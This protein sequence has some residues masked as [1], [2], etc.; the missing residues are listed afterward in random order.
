MAPKHKPEE[1][2][3]R[4]DVAVRRELRAFVRMEPRRE[5]HEKNPKVALPVTSLE[6]LTGNPD[7]DHL[8]IRLSVD[9]KMLFIEDYEDGSYID[10]FELHKNTK[11]QMHARA[12]DR[13]RTGD[14]GELQTG[15]S[16]LT[17]LGRTNNPFA[18]SE[19][20]IK[21]G[22]VRAED[23]EPMVFQIS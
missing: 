4:L 22:F 9:G 6:R 10:I 2:L 23:G 12:K 1:T 13:A 15:S 5:R 14:T 11:R 20:Q 8:F 7:L 16:Y 18:Q 19:A 3:R 17:T 21:S